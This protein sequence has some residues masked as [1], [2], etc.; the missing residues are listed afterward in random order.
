MHLQEQHNQISGVFVETFAI[1]INCTQV[2]T[3][4]LQPLWF[5]CWMWAS[6]YIECLFIEDGELHVPIPTDTKCRPLGRVPWRYER[7]NVRLCF[8]LP[9]IRRGL[10]SRYRCYRF[11]RAL[12]SLLPIWLVDPVQNNTKEILTRERK[13]GNVHSS[14]AHSD[15]SSRCLHHPSCASFPQESIHKDTTRFHGRVS[16]TKCR[17]HH[18]W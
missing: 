13:N 5:H 15:R 17:T 11:V 18:G 3:A 14:E 8:R 10:V 4:T 6:L 7:W 9:W 2:T 12:G 16:E 1:G